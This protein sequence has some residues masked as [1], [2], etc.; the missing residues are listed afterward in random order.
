MVMGRRSLGPSQA[1]PLETTAHRAV[2]IAHS[3]YLL[4]MTS[5]SMFELYNV[6]KPPQEAWARS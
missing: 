4:I 5:L 2:P 1:S 6:R 3:R